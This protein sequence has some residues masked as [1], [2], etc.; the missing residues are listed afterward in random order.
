MIIARRFSAGSAAPPNALPKVFSV[1]IDP[2]IVLPGDP[3]HEWPEPVSNLRRDRGQAPF[4]S[5][6]TTKIGAYVGH[7]ALFSRP[8]GTHG[9]SKPTP[10]AEAPG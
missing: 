5:K 1:V 2:E 3:A 4:G 9:N 7:N 8:C 6:H 10:G